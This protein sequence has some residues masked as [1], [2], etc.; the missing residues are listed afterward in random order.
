MTDAACVHV[1]GVIRASSLVRSC[2]KVAWNWEVL[3]GRLVELS[4]EDGSAQLTLAVELV[5]DAQ[6]HA[7]PVAWVTEKKSGF[8]PP[9]VAEHG[10]DLASLVVVRTAGGQTIPR[11]AE[12]LAR[13]GAFGLVVLD[14]GKDASVPPPLLSRLMKLAQQRHTMVLFLTIKSA[15][16]ASLGSLMSLRGEARYTRTAENSFAC[17]LRILKDKRGPPTWTHREDCRGPMGVR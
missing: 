9:D 8:F 16:A 13:S 4:S 17:E 1:P 6:R 12:M 11:A 2:G 7:Q 5:A 3:A 14:L 15:D 10:V